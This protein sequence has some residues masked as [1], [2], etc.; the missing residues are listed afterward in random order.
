MDHADL[1][2]VHPDAH[3][4]Q[5]H[6]NTDHTSTFITAADVPFGTPGA[7]AP[8]DTADAGVA[9][10][11]ARS[12]HR[13]AITTAAPNN[14][15]YTLTLTTPTATGGTFGVEFRGESNV[16]LGY[17]ITA[18]QLQTALAIN[19]E[20][21]AGNITVTGGPL[22]TGPFTLTFSA[23]LGSPTAPTI[24]ANVLTG[25]NSPYTIAVAA[26]P[27]SG[28]KPGDIPAEGVAVFFARS[29]H[30]H[31]REPVQILE[32]IASSAL[33]ISTTV[34][35]IPGISITFT[36]TNANALVLA[37]ATFDYDVTLAGSTL[38]S[39]YVRL[40]A[41][42]DVLLV[43]DDLRWVHRYTKFGQQAFTV[44]TPGSHTIVMRGNK[45]SATGTALL[46]TLSR[47]LLVVIG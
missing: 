43:F 15:A 46:N 26:I 45:N 33:T 12:D 36:T 6:G 23:S 37:F 8:D 19:P 10:S 1:V 40:D 30:V 29:D 27:V 9:T 3:H 31:G 38:A 34:T 13:H 32:D 7:I 11:Y 25:P 28:S 17:N 47:L 39:G 5:R 22:N 21:G 20:I 2:G 42:A 44:A 41:G 16:G 4:A 24:T 35:D 18:A 14:W